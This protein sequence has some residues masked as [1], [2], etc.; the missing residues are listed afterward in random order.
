MKENLYDLL[1]IIGADLEYLLPV[2]YIRPSLS[3]VNNKFILNIVYNKWILNTY[4]AEIMNIVSI[5]YQHYHIKQSLTLLPRMAKF[6][7]CQQQVYPEYCLQQVDSE[8]VQCRDYEYRQHILPT[9]SYQA[10]PYPF[11]TYG[12]DVKDYTNYNNWSSSRCN[13][14]NNNNK[15][16]NAS[17]QLPAE[18][19]ILDHLSTDKTLF[20]TPTTVFNSKEYPLYSSSDYLFIDFDTTSTTPSSEHLL[21]LVKGDTRKV[22]LVS[23]RSRKSK[24]KRHRGSDNHICDVCNK[25]FTCRSSL[26]RSRFVCII[27]HKQFSQSGNMLRHRRKVHE[28]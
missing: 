1:L 18:D 28:S 8:Y 24:Q 27:C 11:T 17:P 19:S 4:N 12:F 10:V 20:V 26:V 6:V 9:L 16:I 13:N 21:S 15:S 14:N 5:S 2:T 22:T 25:T 7:Y 3:T 23:R